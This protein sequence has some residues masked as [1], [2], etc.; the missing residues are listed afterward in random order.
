M[1][2]VR[3][4]GA[5]ALSLTMILVAASALG[6]RFGVPLPGTVEIV[7]VLVL[8]AAAA[9]IV[10]ATLERAHASA[11]LIVDHLPPAY[12]RMVEVVGIVLGIVFCVAMAV[13]NSWLLHDVWGLHEAS[14]LLGI[15][16]VPFRILFVI[17]L[18][19]TALLLCLQLRPRRAL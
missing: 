7:E 13:G 11:R 9:G 1:T 3:A 19:V 14:H 17:T 12:R 8:V 5:G 6:R 4:A 10:V 15:P 2:I 18:I 16:I